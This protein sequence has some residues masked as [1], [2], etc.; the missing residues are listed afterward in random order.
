MA[1]TASAS[2]SVKWAASQA[3][4]MEMGQF[5]PS[6]GWLGGGQGS[7]AQ[8]S[9]MQLVFREGAGLDGA[10]TLRGLSL[11]LGPVSGF[12][13]LSPLVGPG[14]TVMLPLMSALIGVNTGDPRQSGDKTRR[15][16]R[17]LAGM[18]LY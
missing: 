11:G 4:I 13:P 12:P 8:D 3:S 1:S 2:S 14:R 9:S 7:G 15:E 10:T 18:V 5:S 17:M 16:I 6:L